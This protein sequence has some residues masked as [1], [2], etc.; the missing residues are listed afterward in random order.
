M[1]CTR[2]HM[3]VAKVTEKHVCVVKYCWIIFLV[4]TS[5]T[6]RVCVCMRERECVCV[7]LDVQAHVRVHM[8][9]RTQGCRAG[10]SVDSDCSCTVGIVREREKK[11]EWERGREGTRE[12]DRVCVRVCWRRSKGGGAGNKLVNGISSI[13]VSHDPPK[14]HKVFDVIPYAVKLALL[15]STRIVIWGNNSW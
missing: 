8:C 10:N 11:R 9:V 12:R 14:R 15:H 1:L 13:N 5:H 3:Y 4:V 7:W 2:S 6:H